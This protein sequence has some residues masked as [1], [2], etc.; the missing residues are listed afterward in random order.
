MSRLNWKNI[1]FLVVAL[2]I[3]GRYLYYT[4][5]ITEEQRVLQVIDRAQEAVVDKS[6][7]RLVEVVSED[8]RD[9]SGLDRSSILRLAGMYFKTQ[10]SVEIIRMGTDI[11]FP[12]EGLAV[13]TLRVQIIGNVGGQWGRGVTDDSVLGEVFTVRL[14]RA[15][16]RWRIIAVDPAKGGWP[17]SV[18]F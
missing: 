5:G 3:L 2:I 1:L 4:L 11:K 8:Y 7:V 13:A 10:D 9:S 17:K 12:E 16:S 14:R 15:D 18:G 6:L